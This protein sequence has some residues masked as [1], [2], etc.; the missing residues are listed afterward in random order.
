MKHSAMGVT[1]VVTTA[2]MTTAT[3]TAVIARKI[4]DSNSPTQDPD[5]FRGEGLPYSV[6]AQ[7]KE[8]GNHE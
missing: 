7:T 5:A 2:M 6:H 4:P 8:E 3:G 1:S